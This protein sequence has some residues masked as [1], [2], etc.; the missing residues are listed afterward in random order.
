MINPFPFTARV[1]LW[2]RFFTRISYRRD[3]PLVVRAFQ[4]RRTFPLPDATWSA[5]E[6]LDG[7]LSRKEAGVLHWVARE[8]RAPGPVLEL[9]SYAGRS[10]VV[11]AR[12]GRT[13]HAVDAWSLDVAD[14]SAFGGG[15][16]S[17]DAVFARFQANLR[18][19]QVEDRVFTHRGL[20][21]EVAR[22][23]DLDGAILFIDAG[24]TYADVRGDL[25]LWTPHLKR[26]GILLMHDVLGDVYLNVTRAA[27]ELLREGWRVQASAGSIVAFTRQ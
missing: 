8:W 20:T 12:A 25:D 1:R 17:A 10:T 24:H 21:H 19:A 4:A 9:G 2:F 7:F 13:V 15:I 22:Q 11:F 16:T 6:P 5:I 18:R 23:W 27:S 3:L 26:D 14:L